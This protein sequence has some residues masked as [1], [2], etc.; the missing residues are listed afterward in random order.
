MLRN[1]RRPKYATV[2]IGSLLI[3]LGVAY[4]SASSPPS[5]IQSTSD[6]IIVGLLLAVGGSMLGA[7]LNTIMAGR[8]QQGVLDEIRD[9]VAGSIPASFISDEAQLQAFRHQ[10]HHYYLTQI[11]GDRTWWYEVCAFD[12]ARLVGS[13]TEQ[14]SLRAHDGDIHPYL[15]E[16]GVR[17]ERLI[18]LETRVDGKEAGCVEIFP[19]PRGFQSVHTG[20]AVL[21]T[22][23]GSNVLTKAIIARKPLVNKIGKGRVPD[24]AASTLDDIWRTDFDHHTETFL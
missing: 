11:G 8:Y 15:A 6:G 1:T 2:V 10:W 3:A 23:T 20:V 17:G 12:S 19:R 7:G 14:T 9:V 24:T 21:E 13:L 4:R 5:G 16:V 18:F 22:W